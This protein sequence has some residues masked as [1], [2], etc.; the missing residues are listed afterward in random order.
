MAAALP[1]LTLGLGVYST[2]QS[3]NLQQQAITAAREPRLS[4]AQQ[5]TLRTAGT[6][7]IGANLAQRGLLDSSLYT[8]ALTDL[9]RRIGEATAGAG[10]TGNV[11]EMLWQ[12]ALGLGQSGAG[13]IGNLAQIYMLNR[14]FGGGSNPFG[15]LTNPFGTA[16]V[17]ASQGAPGMGLPGGWAL[18][19]G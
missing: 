16:V 14:L 17:P 7:N 8:G 18:P 15:S 12:Q 1:F 19:W 11:P 3:Q 9:E 5:A 4:E 6:S 10:T 2:I 13:T